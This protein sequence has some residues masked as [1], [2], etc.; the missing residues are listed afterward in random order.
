MNRRIKKKRSEKEEEHLVDMS[1][2]L[3]IKIV[4]S[5]IEEQDEFQRDLDEMYLKIEKQMEAYE[6]NLKRVIKTTMTNKVVSIT[7]ADDA[8]IE[9]C[10]EEYRNRNIENIERRYRQIIKGLEETGLF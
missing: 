9:K 8:Y 5:T 4:E 7:E 2:R 6:D 3:S 1:A 10:K